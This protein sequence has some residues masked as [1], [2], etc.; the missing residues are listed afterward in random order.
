MMYANPVATHEVLGSLVGSEIGSASMVY[1]ADT[2]G[3]Y[4]VP[5]LEKKREQLYTDSFAASLVAVAASQALVRGLATGPWKAA[6]VILRCLTAFY[7][8]K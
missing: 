1:V 3:E 5:D 4:A 8:A 7:A 6:L 2:G